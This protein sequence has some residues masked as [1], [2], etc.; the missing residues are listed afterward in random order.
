MYDCL[1]GLL[2]SVACGWDGRV[3]KRV[4]ILVEKPLGKLSHG[5]ERNR[6]EENIKMDLKL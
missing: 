5:R 4:Q 2:V 6:S 3:K 1:D